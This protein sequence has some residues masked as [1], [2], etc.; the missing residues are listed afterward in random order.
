MSWRKK[1]GRGEEILQKLEI[2]M[3]VKPMISKFLSHTAP[4]SDPLWCPCRQ[5]SQESTLNASLSHSWVLHSFYSHLN[6]QAWFAPMS[7]GGSDCSTWH[8]PMDRM[9]SSCI[10]FI[11]RR[12]KDQFKGRYKRICC[13]KVKKDQCVCFHPRN[14]G[15]CM[16]TYELWERRKWESCVLF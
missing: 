4:Y 3:Y 6:I 14:E 7:H 1:W 8:K 11:S 5:P 2:D 10:A 9:H 12:K 15:K 13:Q 16:Y